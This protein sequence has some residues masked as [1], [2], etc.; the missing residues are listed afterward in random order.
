[1]W[2]LEARRDRQF[3]K[4]LLDQSGRDGLQKEML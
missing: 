2:E 1:V 4:A 3:F